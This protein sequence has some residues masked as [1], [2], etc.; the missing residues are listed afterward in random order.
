MV[1]KSELPS[2]QI[3]DKRIFLRTDLN[4]PLENGII[5]DDFKLKELLPT[6]NL[7]LEKKSKIILATHIGRADHPQPELS[8]RHLIPWFR[9]HGYSIEYCNTLEEAEQKSK[10][11]SK[12]IVLLEN[13][14]FYP[15]EKSHDPQFAQQLKKLAEWY[16][17]DAFGTLHRTDTSV[18]ALPQLFSIHQKTFG[19]LI[20]KELNQAQKLMIPQHPFCLIVGGG[21]AAD[22][23][24]LIKSLLPK[25]D[26]VL[27]CPGIDSAFAQNGT[28]APAI[29]SFAKKNRIAIETPEDYLVGKSLDKGPFTI[30]AKD[31]LI[32]GDFP[33]SIGPAT[34][35]KYAQIISKSH[36]A[37]YN[38]LM[39]TLDNVQ[40]LQGVHALF[41]AMQQCD[42]AL[43]GG[44]DS[45]AAARKLGFEKT[46]NLSTGGGAL[47]AYLS[48]QKLPALQVLIDRAES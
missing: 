33:I 38:G 19:L 18:L 28:D 16:V 10:E 44:G 12:S 41:N 9:H 22:K 29:I 37:F 2:W 1:Y 31:V 46:L 4:I 27:L 39:G 25:L 17:N 8:T 7:L 47:L 30:K 42:F 26:S 24:P 20:Q 3:S 14:R 11:D 34:Q 13:L 48:G 43:V 35:Q 45:T 40:T 21:K 15:G 23:I 32:P 6:L 36:T 5:K